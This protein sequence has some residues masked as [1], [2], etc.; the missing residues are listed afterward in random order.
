M[1]F[2]LKKNA[3]SLET[4]RLQDRT[5]HA[6]SP[7]TSQSVSQQ[8]AIGLL[9]LIWADIGGGAGV[10]RTEGDQSFRGHVLSRKSHEGKFWF[11]GGETPKFFDFGWMDQRND[12]GFMR[13][14]CFMFC[15]KELDSAKMNGQ[16]LNGKW[17]KWWFSQ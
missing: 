6:V 9:R 17:E 7:R 13:W 5:S 11:L 4:L 3:R 15:Q 12:F 8:E 2:N 10:T 14:F 16:Q 1:K